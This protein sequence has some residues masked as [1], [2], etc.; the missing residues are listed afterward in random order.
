MEAIE[1]GSCAGEGAENND[2]YYMLYKKI[3]HTVMG[4]ILAPISIQAS[5]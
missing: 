1:I 4:E 3:S 5:L 2:F